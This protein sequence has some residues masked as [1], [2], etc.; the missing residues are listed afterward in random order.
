[1]YL[2]ELEIAINL[3]LSRLEIQVSFSLL[4]VV[5]LHGIIFYRYLKWEIILWKKKII[6]ALTVIVQLEVM[7]KKH[8]E[9]SMRRVELLGIMAMLMTV[10]VI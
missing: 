3:W 1:M 9:S 7:S 5:K 8:G 4:L 6:L 2:H 10:W